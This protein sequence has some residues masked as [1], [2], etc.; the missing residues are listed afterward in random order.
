[1][2]EEFDREEFEDDE[3]SEEIESASDEINEPKSGSDKSEVQLKTNL[4]QPWMLQFLKRKRQPQ[5][6]LV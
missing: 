6:R 1:M 5:L 2:D 3:E 4:Y